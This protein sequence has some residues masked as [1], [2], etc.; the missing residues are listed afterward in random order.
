MRDKRL[1][2]HMIEAAVR[3][4]AE[5]T[6]TNLEFFSACVSIEDGDVAVSVTFDNE[7]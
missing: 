3:D 5:E 6:D 7:N 1:L 4:Y 2:R